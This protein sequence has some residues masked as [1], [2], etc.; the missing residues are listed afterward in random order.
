MVEVMK[1]LFASTAI[2]TI[3]MTGGAFAQSQGESVLERVLGNVESK[4]NLLNVAENYDTNI[5]STVNIGAAAN[6]DSWT[7]TFV[8]G[9]DLGDQFFGSGLL[10]SLDVTATNLLAPGANLSLESELY[11][12][13]SLADS[14]GTT[15]SGVE[16][17]AIGAVNTGTIGETV[18]ATSSEASDSVNAIQMELSNLAFESVAEPEQSVAATAE[19]AP[20]G[21]VNLANIGGNYVTG[22]GTGTVDASVNVTSILAG[23]QQTAENVGGLTTTGIGAVNTGDI[24]ADITANIGT[25]NFS[26][27]N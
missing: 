12:P 27:I 14:L 21:A 23:V 7:Q 26:P 8:T 20:S 25:S 10:Q 4:V 9:I 19:F 3:A 1:K 16:T 11:N 5:D 13:A 24:A 2:A 15:L 6:G 18:G 17:T 22:T